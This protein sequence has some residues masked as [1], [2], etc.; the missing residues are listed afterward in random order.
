MYRPLNERRLSP[1]LRLYDTLEGDRV[2]RSRGQNFNFLA[3]A[4][5]LLENII[6][7]QGWIMPELWLCE[8]RV[9]FQFVR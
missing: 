5:T 8:T 9:L 6:L 4:S 1:G 2:L 3:N 7:L